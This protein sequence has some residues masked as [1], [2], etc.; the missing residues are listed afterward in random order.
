M[1]AVHS[2]VLPENQ[3]NVVTRWIEA[4]FVDLYQRAV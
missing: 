1:E 2:K 3:K 4:F